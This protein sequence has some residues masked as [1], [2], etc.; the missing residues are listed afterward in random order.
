MNTKRESLVR[1]VACASPPA[2]CDA[3]GAPVPAS[4][5]CMA[6]ATHPKHSAGGASLRRLTT[7]QPGLQQKACKGASLQRRQAR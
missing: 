1:A 2:G 4:A 5:H 3:S 7:P 6:A